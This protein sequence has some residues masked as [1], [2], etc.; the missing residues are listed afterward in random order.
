MHA[1]QLIIPVNKSTGVDSIIDHQNL[2]KVLYLYNHHFV[3]SYIHM[4][5]NNN[6]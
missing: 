6:Y 4:A 5:Y 2:T 1:Q 3:S